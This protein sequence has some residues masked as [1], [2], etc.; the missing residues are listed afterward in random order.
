[1]GSLLSQREVY[2]L[3]RGVQPNTEFGHSL[4]VGPP[5]PIVSTISALPA[6]TLSPQLAWAGWASQP[7]Q[8]AHWPPYPRSPHY[9]RGLSHSLVA[10]A[11]IL[12]IGFLPLAALTSKISCASIPHRATPS[13]AQ[14]A[15]TAL[16]LTHPHLPL[17][18]LLPAVLHPE[19]QATF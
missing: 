8:R 12:A 11:T 7:G 5:G 1:M 13:N 19:A 18:T 3:V 9:S 17:L 6:S 10:Q 4:L 14:G 16:R 2:F 15:V